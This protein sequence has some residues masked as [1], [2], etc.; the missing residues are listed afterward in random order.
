M[1]DM[2]KGVDSHELSALHA[3]LIYAANCAKEVGA[4]RLARAIEEA[5]EVSRREMG[6]TGND[7]RTSFH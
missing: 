1:D 3:L 4:D 6:M 7:D 2:K 5:Q